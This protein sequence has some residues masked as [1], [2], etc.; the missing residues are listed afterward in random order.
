MAAKKQT[1]KSKTKRV[2]LSDFED[3]VI[4]Q[5]AD[6]RGYGAHG[7]STALRVIVREWQDQQKQKEVS[8]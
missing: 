7:Y 2:T 6:Q 1:F 3:R 4:Q 5:V 8:R